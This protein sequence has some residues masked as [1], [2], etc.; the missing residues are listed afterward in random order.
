MANV[1]KIKQA[2]NDFEDE[3]YTNSSDI[4]RKEIKQ[5]INNFLK[6]K[7]QLKNDPLKIETDDDE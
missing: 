7:L 3:K 1:D 4:L 2:F 6:D 5:D